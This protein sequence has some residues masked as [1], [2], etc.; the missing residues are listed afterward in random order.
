MLDLED[1]VPQSAKQIARDSIASAWIAL[2]AAGLP[3]VIRINALDSP[4]GRDDLD[5]FQALG[6]M[7]SA[8]ALIVPKAESRLDLDRLA[9]R[10]PGVVLL[11][12]IESAAGYAALIDIAGATGVLRLVVGHIDFMADTG[13]QCSAD[14]PELAPLRFA[15]AMATRLRQLAPAVDG[16]TVDIDDEGRLHADTRRAMR[17]GFGAKLCIHPR[18][19]AIVNASIGPSTEE[20][21]W[22]RRVIAAD[23]SAGGAAVQLDGRMVDAPVVLQARR[24]LA[25]ERTP[26]RAGRTIGA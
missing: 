6:A 21:A 11:P 13:L 18:Q 25:R 3:L 22:A 20:L 19:V 17:F 23:E 24:M 9:R 16:A 14:E 4:S 15:V 8:V 26:A 7:T 1:S 10:L 12:I 2:Q 5:W